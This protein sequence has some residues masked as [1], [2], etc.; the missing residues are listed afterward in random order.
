MRVTAIR[1]HPIKACR[2]VAVAS[3][4]LTARGLAGDRRWMV[5]DASGRFLT[6]RD[7]TELALVQCRRSG[8]RIDLQAPGRP[9]ISIPAAPTEGAPRRVTVWSAQVDAIAHDVA[10]RWFSALL[11]RDCEAVYM[12]DDARRDVRGRDGEIVSFADGYPYLLTSEASLADLNARLHAPIT[13]ERFRPNIVV[14]GETPFAEDGWTRI[15]IGASTFTPTTGCDRCVVTTVDPTTGETG[16]EPLRTLATFRKR[17][18][19]VWFGVNL[20][21]PHAGRIA[22]GDPVDVGPA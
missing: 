2:A 9:S 22:V 18:G 1:I 7:H 12:P 17:D 3:A 20:V 16:R 19:K 8:D 21:G 6:Q 4:A 15:R 11:G 14:D 5:V 13:M 10:G